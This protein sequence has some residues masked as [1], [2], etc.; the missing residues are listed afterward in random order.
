MP[1]PPKGCI[2]CGKSP[3]TSEDLVPL[4]AS[5]ILMRTKPPP[6]QPGKIVKGRHRRWSEGAQKDVNQEWDRKDTPRFTVKCV[7][8]ECN[9]GWMSEIE[10]AAKPI[11]TAMMEDQ[12]IILDTGDQEKVAKWLG[13]K[14]IIAQYGLPQGQIS[15]EWTHAF[16]IEKCP[17]TSWQIRIAHYQGTRPVFWVTTPLDT[18]I[19]HSLV[20]FAMKRPGFLFVAQLGHFVGQVQGIRQQTWIVPTQRHFIQIWPHP[21][22]RASSPDRAQIVSVTWPPEAGLDDSDLEKCA[23][24][25]GEPK[26]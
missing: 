7:C 18:I 5:K 20:P 19:I 24:H 15:P 13:L 3:T 10:N 25:A 9:N 14:A 6:S 23:R 11:M 16:A 17:P 21:L 22:L 2:F 4:W 12:R 26:K 8:G 1:P